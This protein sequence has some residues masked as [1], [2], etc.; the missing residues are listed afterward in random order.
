MRKFSLSKTEKL[1][2]VVSWITISVAFAILFGREFL[3]IGSFIILLPIS[4]I[5]VGTGF[6]LHELAHKYFAIR[7]GAWAEYRA[8][9]VG[10]AIALLSS[11]FGFIFAAPGAVYIMGNINKRQNGI[12]SLA[13]PLTNI[14]FGLLF[15]LAHFLLPASGIASTI[16]KF[17]YSINFFLAFFNMLPIFVLDGAKVFAWNKTIWAAVFIPLLLIVVFL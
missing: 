6:I 2:L 10:L 3:N 9:N 1:E 13:G 8:W 17:G 15:L 14:A 16:T 12:V 4:L 11:F 7:Y 5:V